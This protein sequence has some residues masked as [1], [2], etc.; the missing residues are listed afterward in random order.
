MIVYGEKGKGD[1]SQGTGVV[2]FRTIVAIRS[3]RNPT[4]QSKTASSCLALVRWADLEG[5]KKGRGQAVA[6]QAAIVSK[7]RIPALPVATHVGPLTARS[8]HS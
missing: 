2:F 7:G 1:R 6:E 5:R 3:L 8:T 4:L